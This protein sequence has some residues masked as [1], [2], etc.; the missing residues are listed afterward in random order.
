MTSQ[1][2]STFARG[3]MASFQKSDDY[4]NK[5]QKLVHLD[6]KGAPPKINYY[7]KL[8]PLL[9]SLGATG[10]LV[11][12]EDM[13]PYTSHLQDLACA[14]AYSFNDIQQLQ[15]LANVCGLLFIPLVQ[16]FGHLEYVLKHNRF[17]HLREMEH[18]PNS[19]CPSQEQSKWVVC[20][21]ISQMLKAHPEIK[22]IHIGADEVWNLGQCSHCTQ[23]QIGNGW[24]NHRLYLQHV[25]DVARFVK[26][27][28]SQVN[29]II[30]D[31]MI[32][33]VDVEDLLESGVQSLVEPMIWNYCSPLQLPEGIWDRFS[34][35]FGSIWIASAFKG[36]TGVHKMLPDLAHYVSN[37]EAW[38][39]VLPS[40]CG[41][42]T[43]KGWVLTGWQRYDHFSV[44]CELLPTSMPSLALCLET[45]KNGKFDGSVKE[46]AS[47]LLGSSK[48]ID[49]ITQPRPQNI[50]KLDFPNCEIFVGIQILAN[51]QAQYHTWLLSDGFQ[52]W[53]SDYHFKYNFCNPVRIQQL[54]AEATPFLNSFQQL[55][56]ELET[57]F[58]EIYFAKTIEE[59]MMENI[60][61]ELM[62]VQSTVEKLQSL[63]M[64]S[65]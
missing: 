41:S 38:L 34:K 45:I 25:V 47:K 17:R 64:N 9:K 54:L 46:S 62:Q 63:L 56:C 49:I 19:I 18:V 42:F 26:R 37:H 10:L 4:T 48:T 14:E 11:E 30:W 23:R 24:T 12:Y 58:N 7:K 44:L 22:W 8:F 32:R 39:K 53:F 20:E 59:W 1:T 36:A 13:F 33:S 21:M 61:V 65:T 57:N 28:Q 6:L 29:V 3:S 31:D 5:M 50:L 52:G 16:T 27:T 40:L 55:K 51:L 60:D 35:V 2:N 15:H 43:V